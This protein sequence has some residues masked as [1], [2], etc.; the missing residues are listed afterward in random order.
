[1]HQIDVRSIRDLL[2]PAT[3]A[4]LGATCLF[5]WVTLRQF[6]AAAGAD[7]SDRNSRNGGVLGGTVAT[8]APNLSRLTARMPFHR[9]GQGSD[10]G[11]APPSRPTRLNLSIDGIFL[12][13]EPSESVA[14]VRSGNAVKAARVGQ[15]LGQGAT[16]LEVF[17]DHVIVDNRG[18]R[19][20]L[21]LEKPVSGG[22]SSSHIDLSSF[23]QRYAQHGGSDSPPED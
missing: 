2:E 4:L 20:R 5:A 11:G 19:E 9:S 8:N 15:P 6:E 12:M 10:H 17:R 3:V 23:Y 1:M 16:L 22:G 7:D 14:V 21:A 13:P 18:H